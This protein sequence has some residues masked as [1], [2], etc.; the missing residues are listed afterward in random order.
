M[1]PR[2]SSRILH[3]PSPLPTTVIVISHQHCHSFPISV[4]FLVII[5]GI[6]CGDN[7]GTLLVNVKSW[8]TPT[9]AMILMIAPGSSLQ[10]RSL[11]RRQAA[12]PK[13]KKRENKSNVIIPFCTAHRSLSL[14]NELE[15]L[16][17]PPP[18]Y[19]GPGYACMEKHVHHTTL[20][21]PVTEIQRYT[22]SNCTNTVQYIMVHPIPSL[23]IPQL[24]SHVRAK[25]RAR[26]ERL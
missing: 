18:I 2:A 17:V 19:M 8:L 23:R 20:V 21:M 10:V 3:I 15:S 26:Q 14:R 5:F 12:G 11:L 22:S 24:W 4:Y 6:M 16:L 7:H 1:Y 13:K 9:R 25:A